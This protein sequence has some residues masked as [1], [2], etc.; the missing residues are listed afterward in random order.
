[1]HQVHCYRS[2]TR[3]ENTY[4]ISDFYLFTY[5][6]FGRTH[7]FTGARIQRPLF[8]QKAEKI[9]LHKNPR[10]QLLILEKLTIC[11][12]EAVQIEKKEL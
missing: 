11:S 7:L 4:A 5:Y 8:R 3:G 10:P 2:D 12:I 6:N 9:R 1:M